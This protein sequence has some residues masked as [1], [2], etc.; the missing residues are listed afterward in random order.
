MNCRFCTTPVEFNQ[1]KM[2]HRI[3]ELEDPENNGWLCRDCAE[4]REEG[5]K[6]ERITGERGSCIDCDEE[7]TYGVALVKKTPRG[8]V[9]SDGT[10]FQ[11][12]CDEHFED[13]AA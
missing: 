3:F 7:A 5:H 9:E 11:V 8:N 12:L 4:I 6:T 1:Q 10:V 2:A 13:R